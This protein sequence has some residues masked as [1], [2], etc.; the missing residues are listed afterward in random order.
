MCAHMIVILKEESDLVIADE[1]IFIIDALENS[2]YE[3]YAVGG[4]IR[5]S[6][7]GKDPKDWDVCTSALPEQVKMCFEGR[8]II[9]T[10]L[11]HGT[12]TLMLDHKPFE[13]TT[14][15]VDGK[16]KDNRRPET[17]RYVNVLKRDLARRDFTINAMAY[18]PKTGIVDYYGGR[19]DLAN[20]LIKC[21]GNPNKRFKE[22]ALRIMRA[23]R[24]ASVFGFSVE[25]GTAQAMHDNKKLL[26]N[27]AAERI[28][29]ELGGLITGGKAGGIISAHLPVILEI[30]PELEQS[31]G[32]EQNN[33]YHCYDVLSHILF[34]VDAAP[35]ELVIRLTMLLHD[36]AKPK[37]YTQSDDGSGHFHGHPQESSEMSKKILRRLKYDTNTI[38]TVTDLVLYH[39]SDVKQERKHI[40][41]WLN[42]IGE[43]RLRQLLVV[44]R[45][46]AIAQSEKY[47]K[48]KLDGIDEVLALL[49]E[50][51]EQQQV[52]TLKGLA[53]TGRDL[54]DA[55]VAE[56]TQIGVVLRK[57]L[58]MVI[59]EEAENDKAVLLAISKELIRGGNR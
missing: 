43:V 25:S 15:R 22:D 14:Y 55:G 45:A 10:G 4:C 8:H 54:I 21:V 17:V 7:L 29:V 50:I 38:E 33:P 58:D 34:S 3:A 56:G 6:L 37:C 1:V 12:V 36:I 11:R 39:D 19:E 51:I 59:A 23:M 24:F 53:L 49:D 32:F 41:R 20:G 44:K 26:G 18:N 13:I 47:R 35:R 27:I 5:D 9:E 52:F 48:A 28:A 16:Y 30:I 42:K 2:G 57:L 31:I 46:D 40:K